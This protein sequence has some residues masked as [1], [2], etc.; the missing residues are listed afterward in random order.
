MLMTA[1]DDNGMLKTSN[2]IATATFLLLF[3]VYACVQFS[4]LTEVIIMTIPISSPDNVF[5]A[6]R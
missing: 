1:D 6:V 2:K 3:V 4:L 5:T